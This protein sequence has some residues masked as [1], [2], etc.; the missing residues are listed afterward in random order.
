VERVL[1]M[2][3]GRGLE[4]EVYGEE[5]ESFQVEVFGGEVESVDR[6]N[7]TG[8]GMRAV[9]GGRTGFAWTCDPSDEGLAALLAEAESNAASGDE[10]DTDVLAGAY[11]RE[12]L[13]GEKRQYPREAPAEMKIEGALAMEAA[14]LAA[15]G[16]IKGSEG[17]SYSEVTY[18]ICVAGTRGFLRTRRG[19]YCSCS[20]GAAATSAGEV[21]SGWSYAQALMPGML[22]FR[23]TGIEAGER[24]AGLLGGRPIPT[25]RYA[26]VFDALAFTEIISMLGEVLSAEMVVR[27]SSVFNGRLGAKVASDAFT[28]IDDPFIAGGC[29]NAPFDDEGVPSIRRELVSRGVLEGF[30]HN[31][32]SARKMGR[33]KAGNA[34]RGSFKSIPVP[35][36]TNFFVA[37]GAV[38]ED[39]L[40]ESLGNGIYIQ[41]VMGMHTADPV[42]GDFSV[43]ITGYEVSGGKKERAVCEMTISGN[44]VSLL[45]RIAAAGRAVRFAGQVGSPPVL[46]DGL[47]VSGR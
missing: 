2:A 44:V 23:K 42:S 20:T 41:D 5:T 24:A 35:G 12:T 6:A 17:A 32:Y 30:L 11:D 25:G 10:T 22:D 43:G 1:D 15:D 7:E 16:R 18:S 26:V 8:L 21:R 38:E 36:P 3:A 28:L 9:T 27:G 45:E 47:S 4:C 46:V 19:G 33:G 37:P 34:F 40:V 13:A 14:T 29:F 39:E 31:S